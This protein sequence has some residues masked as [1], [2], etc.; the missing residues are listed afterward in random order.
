VSRDELLQ[1]ARALVPALR[2]R[3]QQT[4]EL[5]QMTPETVADLKA[6]GLLDIATPE[7]FGGNGHE[8]DLMFNVAMELGRGCGSTAWCYAVWDIH[9]WMVGH[10]PIEAQE[11]YF[12]TGPDT[13]SSSSFGPMGRLE[14]VEG[15]F[16]MSGRW[17]FSSGSNAG[18]WALLGAMSERGPVFTLV[19]RPDYTVIEDTWQVS[20][21]KGTGSKDVVVDGAFVP[22]HRLMPMMGLGPASGAWQLHQRDSYR[23]VG[24][25]LL[26]F[27]LCSPIV[28]MARGAVEEF[29]NQ[30][31]GKTGPGRGAES[32]QVQMR[33]AESAAEVDAAVRIIRDDS[34]EM[35]ERAGAGETL[36]ELDNAT[37]RRDYGYAA[38]LCV[39]AVNR[40]F[41]ASGGHG[42]FASNAM[43]RFH[44]DIHA[45]S[46]QAA[47]YWDA[48][49]E[50]YGRAALGLPAAEMRR[51]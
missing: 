33:L 1:R 44:R 35:I 11:D 22:A 34:R 32:I 37:Y 38:K 6:S 3:A 41:E 46:H 18:T 10:W 25:S 26:P 12:A 29:T 19:P 49:G 15:G 48:I 23:L 40:L 20:G 5:R 8:I 27:T 16:R 51:G 39:Q 45:G 42:L 13:L 17:E 24:M 47:L 28:G 21:L 4:E 36:S 14:P 2:E 30:M 31:K 50:A 7:R 43:Q 9:N